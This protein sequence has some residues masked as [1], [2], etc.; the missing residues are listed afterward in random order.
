[1]PKKLDVYRIFVDP[2][3][4]GS[5]I[6][7]NSA[8]EHPAHEQGFF[9]FNKEVK[10]FEFNDAKQNIVGIAIVPEKEIYRND[11]EMGEFMVVFS[12]NDVEVMAYLYGKS[13]SWNNLTMNHDDSKPI[14]TAS[15]YYSQVI[16]RDNGLTPPEAFSE[17]PDGTWILGYH[18]EDKEEYEYVRDNF[19]GWSV[20]GNFMIEQI[21]KFQKQNK[22]SKQKMTIA[23]FAKSIFAKNKAK[24][25]AKFGEATLE[26]GNTVVWEGDELVEGETPIFLVT[27]EGEEPAPDGTHTTTDGAV[28]TT[29]G[30]IL[31]SIGVA[32]EQNEDF[33]EIKN[34]IKSNS[35][36]IADI[37]KMLEKSDSKEDF[38]KAE[39]VKDFKEKFEALE[40]E[41][42]ELIERIEKL[43]KSPAKEPEKK[44]INRSEST[45]FKTVYQKYKSKN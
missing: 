24:K 31:I 21:E 8:V 19:T 1:M 34:N 45:Q 44:K 22:M 42:K 35:D 15:M 39:E 32:E 36:A 30:G 29:E 43:E 41:N 40:K 9:A 25:E 20:E 38:A 11:P 17:V 3:I 13:Q 37:K 2:N 14:N 28:L 4:E 27:E 26:D 12:K 10:K 16:D 7:M 23:E 6:T 5:E 18:F 33:E